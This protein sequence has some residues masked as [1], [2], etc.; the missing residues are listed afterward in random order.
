[1][2]VLET[3]TEFHLGS[4]LPLHSLDG[5]YHV[6]SALPRLDTP[7]SAILSFPAF[8]PLL[9]SPLIIDN[10][11][12]YWNI[13]RFHHYRSIELRRETYSHIRVP[14][15]IERKREE[16]VRINNNQLQR[17]ISFFFFRLI[18]DFS[19]G[20]REKKH[21]EKDCIFTKAGSITIIDNQ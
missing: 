20:F 1:M 11:Y 10:R 4:K 2:N 14:T 18:N 3:G 7:V 19:F 16:S 5:F 9:P 17:K 12:L 6:H 8:P 15:V 21:R 13:Y